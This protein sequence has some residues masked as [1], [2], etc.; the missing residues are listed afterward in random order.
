MHKIFISYS[1]AD[2][3]KVMILKNEIEQLLGVGSCWVDLDGIESDQ[4]FVDVIIDAI[5]KADIF[6]FMY[7]RHSDSS[8]WT[9]KE[10]NYAHS[11]KKRIVFVKLENVQLSKYFRFQFGEHD[12]IDLQDKKQKEKLLK[13]LQEWNVKESGV[14]QQVHEKK[15]QKSPQN[16]SN[17]LFPFFSKLGFVELLLFVSA[18]VF[19]INFII[20]LPLFVGVNYKNRDYLKEKY[21]RY[22]K[23]ISS[24]K[25]YIYLLLGINVVLSF[26][27]FCFSCQEYDGSLLIVECVL[28]V[29]SVLFGYFCLYSSFSLKY[30]KK[31]NGVILFGIPVLF[32]FCSILLSLYNK[33]ELHVVSPNVA[34][35]QDSIARLEF[36]TETNGE[37]ADSVCEYNVNESELVRS[38]REAAIHGNPIAQ[39]GLGACYYRGDGIYK[40]YKE[41]VKWWRKAAMQGS[42]NAQYWLGYCYEKGKGVNQNHDEAEKWYRKAA[43][44]GYVDAQSR[45][46]DFFYFGAG[47]TKNYSEAVK[48]WRKA[49][50]QGDSCALY[51]L[52]CCYAQGEGVIQ[53]HEEA[54]KWWRKAAAQGY[55]PAITA[56]NAEGE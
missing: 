56:L 46:G 19:V 39:Y 16:P 23:V 54:I 29:L 14:E 34:E 12:I 52:G 18:F 45:L 13:N 17:S 50:E 30:K 32:Y 21:P 20:G 53:N 37:T 25:I 27:L 49:A 28:F 42:V 44:K 31:H 38:F 7:S 15:E 8:E 4:Q 10:I 35:V 2:Y 48:W 5:D 9:R 24:K 11:E 41:A 3:D 26:F 40:S 1:R 51:N 22:W 33:S 36:Q 43:E 6:L 55:E 47:N